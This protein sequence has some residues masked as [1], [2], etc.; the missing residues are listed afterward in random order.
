M[1]KLEN[2]STQ[3]CI[4]VDSR[5]HACMPLAVLPVVMPSFRDFSTIRKRKMEKG[6]RRAVDAVLV[7]D[8]QDG[9]SVCYIR[10]LHISEFKID[11]LQYRW[12]CFNGTSVELLQ[13]FR[14]LCE[15]SVQFFSEA[16]SPY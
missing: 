12:N 1:A 6:L 13:L 11:R 5:V 4:C 16:T 8:L 10:S 2:A 15:L 7:F 14:F 9:R 3:E